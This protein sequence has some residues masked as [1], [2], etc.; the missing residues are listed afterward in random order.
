VD[1]DDEPWETAAGEDEDGDGD[2][3]EPLGHGTWSGVAVDAAGA[4]AVL[5]E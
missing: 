4:V 3:E 5:R 2:V 1:D